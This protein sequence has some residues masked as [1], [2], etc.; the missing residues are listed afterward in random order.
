[1]RVNQHPTN[2]QPGDAMTRKTTLKVKAK[3]AAKKMTPTDTLSASEIESLFCEAERLWSEKQKLV[4]PLEAA[5]E[6]YDSVKPDMPYTLLL[7]DRD[8]FLPSMMLNG[9]RWVSFHEEH[10]EHIRQIADSSP[11]EAISPCHLRA[12]RAKRVLSD[13]DMWQDKQRKLKELTGLTKADDD[14]DKKYSELGRIMDL[15][16]ARDAQTLREVAIQAVCLVHMTDAEDETVAMAR[17]LA[18]LAGL[19]TIIPIENA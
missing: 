11:G 19:E 15:I 4:D 17:R 7:D 9:R 2:R 10:I 16:R 13:I 8:D 1:M 6:L 12:N 5:T 14:Y 3:T 18:Q